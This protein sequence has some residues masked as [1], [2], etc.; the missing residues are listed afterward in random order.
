M[1]VCVCNPSLDAGPEQAEGSCELYG[2]GQSHSCME[3][4]NGWI[5]RGEEGMEHLYITWGN[6]HMISL[7]CVWRHIGHKEGSEHHVLRLIQ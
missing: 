6:T 2:R 7:V 3:S 1:P 4:K 5:V